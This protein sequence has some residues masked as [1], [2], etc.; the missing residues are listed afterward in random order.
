MA[1]QTIVCPNCGKR[2]PVT[3]VLRS[4]IEAELRPSLDAEIKKREKEIQA[5]FDKK[6]S[7]QKGELLKHA[8]KEAE[9][10]FSK[11]LSKVQSELEQAKKNEKATREKFER[12]LADERA[13][14]EKDAKKKAEERFATQLEE[15]REKLRQKDEEASEVRKQS[16]DVGKLKRQLDARE[17]NLKTEIDKKTEEAVRKVRAE[18]EDEYRTRELQLEKKLGD[19]KKQATEL[20]RKLEQ[21]SQQT[22]GEVQELALEK[23]LA[24]AFPEDKIDRV[25]KGK[26]G[27]DILQRVYQNKQHCGTIIWE[28]KN[29]QSWSK[30]WLP[31]LR[32]DQR[33]EKAELAI[34]VSKV[35]PK[36][37][38]HFAAMDGVWVTEYSLALGVGTALRINLIQVHATRVSLEGKHDKKKVE[39]LFDY[40]SGTE[41]KQRV[42][43]IVE[44][45]ATMQ[46]DLSKER[47]AIEKSW[48]NREKQLKLV[49]QSVAGMYGDL[50][51]IVGPSLPR[52][53]RLELLPG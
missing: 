1:E 10:T 16:A 40:L 15:L 3:E 49:I 11:R 29:T 34:L 31:K 5:A 23:V 53:R 33:R 48:A 17:K 18:T 36:N 19:A 45:F 2:I 12:K 27:A 6:L 13:R 26:S 32:N 38:A 50:Q 7:A 9:G 37:V 14:L 24:K 20:K 25:S 46:D 42:E 44:A 35:L 43:A 30:S 28:S 41:F 52:I 39:L 4:Q 51:G 21:S 22:Q 47:Q 8:T